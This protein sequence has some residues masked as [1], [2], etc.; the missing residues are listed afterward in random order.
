[1]KHHRPPA[2]APLELAW[3]D[4]PLRVV[5][6]EPE[7]PPNTGNIA[8]LCAGTGCPLHLV[9][10]LGFRLTHAALRRAGLDYWDAVQ[11]HRHASFDEFLAGGGGRLRLFS[12]HG[13]RLYTEVDYAPGDALVFGS[14]TRGLPVELLDRFADC[15]VTIPMRPDGV[16]SLNLANCAAIGVYEALRQVQARAVSPA[17]RPSPSGSPVR[18]QP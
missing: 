8:R 12:V 16:R 18:G 7:I 13:R 15:V 17:S 5:L 3:P 14:E 11:L 9:G 10:P 1:M 2:A 6:V 4:P